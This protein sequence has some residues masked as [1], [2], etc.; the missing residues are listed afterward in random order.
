LLGSWGLFNVVFRPCLNLWRKPKR[1]VWYISPANV[2]DRL[3]LYA[4]EA[5]AYS[6]GEDHGEWYE[7]STHYRMLTRRA[8]KLAYIVELAAFGMAVSFRFAQ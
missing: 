6:V 1:S 5:D 8:G 2:Y 3:F 4:L 7:V